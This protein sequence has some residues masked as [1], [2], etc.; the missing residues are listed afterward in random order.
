MLMEN[1]PIKVMDMPKKTYGIDKN[2]GALVVLR[3]DGY[4]ASIEE[5]S[6]K[7]I[8]AIDDFFSKFLLQQEVLGV[9]NHRS[10]ASKNRYGP[11]NNDIPILAV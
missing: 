2:I 10:P 8:L 3:P 1:H 5:L 7:G 9:P 6:K 4:V 11:S